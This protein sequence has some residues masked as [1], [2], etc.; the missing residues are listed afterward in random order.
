MA[1]LGDISKNVSSGPVETALE[2]VIPAWPDV[3]R[4]VPL[5]PAPTPPGGGGFSGHF[6]FG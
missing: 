6:S 4:E 1:A 5:R 3:S 2:L